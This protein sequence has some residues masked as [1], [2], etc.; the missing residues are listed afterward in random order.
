MN[1]SMLKIALLLGCLCFS[2]CGSALAGSDENLPSCL[3]ALKSATRVDGRQ[4]GYA[5][6]KSK[7]YLSYEACLKEGEK[8][9]AQLEALEKPSP[10]GKLYAAELLRRLDKEAGEKAFKALLTDKTPVSYNP[11]GCT[12][13]TLTVG[14]AAHRLLTNKDRL[15]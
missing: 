5:G 15:D 14:A 4:T 2:V 11:G 13:E 8:I 12:V 10:A 7:N 9:R 3:S 1:N 6:S